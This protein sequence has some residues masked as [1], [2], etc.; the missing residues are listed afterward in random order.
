MTVE[1]PK[2]VT[3]QKNK[4]DKLIASAQIPSD[5]HSAMLKVAELQGYE[6]ISSFV[7]DA[8]VEKI[9][10]GARALLGT[11]QTKHSKYKGFDPAVDF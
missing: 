8:I 2:L 10:L 11:V 3:Y 9:E 4:K 6:S 5:V 1:A 7:A